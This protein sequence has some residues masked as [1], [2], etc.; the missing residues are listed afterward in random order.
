MTPSR[1]WRDFLAENPL[2]SNLN[3][4][5]FSRHY[6]AFHHAIASE[7]T[8]DNA[9]VLDLACGT[10]AFTEYLAKNS[11]YYVGL[12]INDRFVHYARQRNDVSFVVGDARKIPLRN[13]CISRVIAVGLFHHLSD[14]ESIEALKEVKRVLSRE[15]FFFVIDAL[16]TSSKYNLV[17]RFCRWLDHGRFVRELDEYGGLFSKCFEIRKQSVI[18][19]FPHESAVYVL[20][21]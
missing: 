3:Q 16:K 2:L 13:S 4:R 12:E 17:G 9:Y 11:R 20:N 8:F 21:H 1:N 19:C 7:V 14:D 5:L 6:S 10:G 15:G 18:T